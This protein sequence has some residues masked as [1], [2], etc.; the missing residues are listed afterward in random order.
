MVIY[1][2]FM[3]II[4]IICVFL[5]TRMIIKNKLNFSNNILLV[6]VFST[7]FPLAISTLFIS[8][9]MFLEFINKN[10]LVILS[11]SVPLALSSLF[12]IIKY[13]KQRIYNLIPNNDKLNSYR[14]IYH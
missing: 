2:F 11:I 7:T 10:N 13:V 4:Y 1:M 8:Y 14:T 9:E 12:Y 5:D 6:L 3:I